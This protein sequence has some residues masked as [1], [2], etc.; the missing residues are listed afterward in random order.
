MPGDRGED[1]SVLRKAIEKSGEELFMKVLLLQGP[2]SVLDTILS[3]QPNVKLTLNW[4]ALQENLYHSSPSLPSGNESNFD[5]LVREKDAFGSVFF[6]TM[7]LASYLLHSN[8]SD[9]ERS[10]P[11]KGA[12]NTRKVLENVY[13][14]FPDAMKLT[15]LHTKY[16][17]GGWHAL[18]FAARYGGELMFPFVLERAGE[19]AARL[20]TDDGILPFHFALQGRLPLEML[21][22]LHDANPEA[23]RNPASRTGRLPLSVR[24]RSDAYAEGAH[25]RAQEEPDA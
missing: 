5:A 11:G 12:E 15:S 18:H 24:A 9:S 21:K 10:V 14:A 3:I 13:N 23:V 16:H 6:H 8:K 1:E 17:N 4:S 2:K 19:M 7:L 20:V 25:H 22:T